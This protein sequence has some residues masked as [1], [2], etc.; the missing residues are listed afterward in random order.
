MT[1]NTLVN[2]QEPPNGKYTLRVDIYEVTELITTSDIFVE[3]SVGSQH[4]K[5]ETYKVTKENYCKISFAFGDWAL[6]LPTF[7]DSQP[8][9]FINIYKSK[10]MS[11]KR[12]GYLALKVKNFLKFF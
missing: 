5:T 10:M 8:L 3:I 7:V 2:A 11:K 12:I 9:L 6:E 1:K 4:V